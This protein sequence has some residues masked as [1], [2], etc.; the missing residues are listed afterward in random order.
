MARER[1]QTSAK[2]FIDRFNALGIVGDDGQPVTVTK[3]TVSK[4]VNG[5]EMPLLGVTFTVT[6]RWLADNTDPTKPK[7]K[8]GRAAELYLE[9]QGEQA[10]VK[11]KARPAAPQQSEPQPKRH[12]PSAMAAGDDQDDEPLP[13][14][15]ELRAQMAAVGIRI[16]GSSVGHREWQAFREAKKGLR[17][18]VQLD[19]D[20]KA[21]V[22]V[23]DVAVETAKTMSAIAKLLD[24]LPSG[25][26]KEVALLLGAPDRAAEVEQVIRREIQNKKRDTVE[27]VRADA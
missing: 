15:E 19:T 25:I 6:M 18:A 17:E 2:E 13:G 8:L 27:A 1:P 7:S 10:P 5:Q 14:F 26:A 11:A 12:E 9:G 22:L 24:N 20:M 21:V 3:G 23:E 4:L 16:T